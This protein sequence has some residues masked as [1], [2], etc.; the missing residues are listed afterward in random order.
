MKINCIV[1][2]VCLLA[3]GAVPGAHAQENTIRK[4]IT[5]IQQAIN[6]E[7]LTGKGSMA[8]SGSIFYRESTDVYGQDERMTERSF[9]ATPSFSYFIVDNISLGIAVSYSYNRITRKPAPADEKNSFV[10]SGFGPAVTKYFGKKR[11]RPFVNVDYIVL[12]G[13]RAKGSQLTMGLGC[14]YHIS[15]SAGIGPHV[16]YGIVFPDDRSIKRSR[17]LYIGVSVASFIFT[18]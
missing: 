15:N 4:A 7:L 13:D 6:A 10:Q 9:Q 16:T 3:A 18:M 12:G 2:A 11:V 17:N 1:Y 8:V 5:D 14:I